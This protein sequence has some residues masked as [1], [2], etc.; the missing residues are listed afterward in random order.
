MLRQKLLPGKLLKIIL[1]RRWWDS[2][3]SFSRFD[4]SVPLIH[5]SVN[6]NAMWGVERI[7]GHQI[8]D[9]LQTKSTESGIRRHEAEDNEI[10]QLSFG[11][12]DSPRSDLIRQ[13][14][15]PV[16]ALRPRRGEPEE[17]GDSQA[18][19]GGA[20]RDPEAWRWRR[21]CPNTG[22]ITDT[23]WRPCD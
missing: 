12:S 23:H 16:L 14:C 8:G 2:R 17:P 22:S 5:L 10:T 19:A 21:R 20:V 9:L 13:P 1:K 4:G 18:A 3:R 11:R 6:R 15:Q 7:E